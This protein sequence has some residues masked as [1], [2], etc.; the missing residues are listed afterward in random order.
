MLRDSVASGE[1][2]LPRELAGSLP[3]QTGARVMRPWAAFGLR[4]LWKVFGPAWLVMMA[5]VDAPSVITAM[6]TGAAFKYG[7]IVVLLLLTIPLYFVSEVTGRVGSVT[8]KG[9]GQL[10][11]EN[12][13]RKIAVALSFPMAATDFLSYV[14]EYTGIAVGATII[15]ISPLVALSIVYIVHIIIVYNRKYAFAEKVLLAVSMVMLVAYL[16]FMTRGASSYSLIPT[17]ITKNFLFLIAA[18]VGAV[19]MPWML[20][21]QAS[22]TAQKTFHSVQATKI[23][24]FVGAMFSEVLMVAIVIVSSAL[25]P[26]LSL[27][28]DHDIARAITSIG[29]MYAPIIFSVGLIAAGFLALVVI[30]LAS[31]WGVSEALALKGDTWFKIYVVESL[32]AVIVP[33]LFPNLI[34]LTLSLMVAF[35]FVLIG[36]V[37]ALGLLAQNTR[38]MGRHS[39]STFD[40][41][42]FWSSVAAVI[43]CG[44]IAFLPAGSSPS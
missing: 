12:F 32:P 23:E 4:D 33:L 7:F 15:G 28:S 39:L 19:I 5:D 6:Q 26:H 31:A 21:F 8:G 30:S 42:A 35:V 9:L 2:P 10:V 3:A 1:G 37:V 16:L 41:V 36:P 17:G 43:A 25:D 44:L 18:N 22:A 40:K 38:L 29:G 14:A 13:S 34:A 20:F 27:T 11:R 24:T